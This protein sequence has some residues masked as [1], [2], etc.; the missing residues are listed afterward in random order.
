MPPAPESAPL[1]RYIV[2]GGKATGDFRLIDLPGTSGR[3]D[4][5]LRCLRAALL[6]SHGVRRDATVH[7]VLGGGE[8]G[9]RVMRVEGATVKF[10]RPDERSL[11]VLAKKALD[12]PR[13]GEGFTVV[14]PGVAVADGGLEVAL[15][16]VGDAPR[17]LLD[18]RGD[19]V[20]GVELPRGAVFLLGDHLGMPEAVQASLGARAVSLG[21]V[22]VHAEDA[23]AVLSNELD[24]RYAGP[25]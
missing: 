18:E 8:A 22:S 10:L 14:R 2:V 7:L 6:V 12:A 5:L 16:D 15:A 21:P 4:A 9:P 23:V 1:R 17:F 25:M 24:R 13:T 19:D 11:A 20:R 3:L